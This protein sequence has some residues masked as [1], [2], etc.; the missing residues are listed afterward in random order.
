MANPNKIWGQTR[1]KVNGRVFDTEGKSSLEVG[2]PMREN[3]AADF[4]AGHFTEGTAPSKATFS[5]LLT[6]DVS[7]TEIQSWDDVTLTFEA[8]TGPIYVVNHG[9][10]SNMPSAS[11]GKAQVEISGPPAEELSA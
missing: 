5:I 9:F 10:T 1:V 6:P 8:D 11:E 7:L 3:V 4:T 2:G